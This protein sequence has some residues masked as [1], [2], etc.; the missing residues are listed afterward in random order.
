MAISCV[1]KPGLSQTDDNNTKG[2]TLMK[3]SQLSQNFHLSELFSSMLHPKD[4]KSTRSTSR[5]CTSMPNLQKPYICVLHL[6][7]SSLGQ[8]GKVCKLLKCLYDMK[9]ARFK[10]YQTLCEFFGEIGFMRSS[11]D[12]TVFFKLGT[13]LSSVISVSTDDM[14]LTGDTIKMIRWVKDRFKERFGDFDLGEIKWLLGHKVNYDKSA[15]TLSI[16]QQ[17]Y[18]DSLVKC[19]KLS[20]MNPVS[21]PMEPGTILSIDQSPSTPCLVAEMQ[22]VPYKEIIGSFAWAALGSHPDISFP[23]SILS[24]FLQNPG[25]THWEAAKCVIC[26]LKGTHEFVLQLTDPKEGIVAYVD[27]DWGLQPHHH[28]ISGHVVSLGGMPIAW[29]S[30]KQNIVALSPTEAEYVA[31]T[32]ALKDIM[33]LCNL[34]SEICMPVTLPTPLMC[35][36]QGTIMLTMNN[37]F[38]PHMKHIDIHYHFIR[39]AVD[40]D[41]VIPIYCP[42]D[43]MVTNMFTKPLACPKLQKFVKMVGLA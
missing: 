14:A 31:M 36:N 7:T 1:T 22:N 16:S 24:Q 8:E 30:H 33:W 21:M 5:M 28:S 32:N 18:I 19:F 23:T 2:L 43:S 11:V 25:C 12:H 38:H 20:N 27:T 3:F 39:L 40:K 13:D 37:K 9:Q 17:T 26:Y 6:V 10:W 15:C 4:E 34:L 41:K 29:E 42:M 35:N